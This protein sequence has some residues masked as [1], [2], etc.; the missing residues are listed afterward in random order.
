MKDSVAGLSSND[1]DLSVTP[2]VGR[3]D[4]ARQWHRRGGRVRQERFA[5]ACGRAAHARSVGAQLAA[6]SPTTT[7]EEDQMNNVQLIGRLTKDPEVITTPGEETLCSLRIAV[8]RMGRRGSTGY[9][10]V[11]VFGRSGAAAGRVLTEGWLVGVYGQL[12]FREWESDG[13]KRN[14]LSVT[15]NVEFLAAPRH[16]QDTDDAVDHALE[17]AA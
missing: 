1:A 4:S 5:L 10:D 17:Q 7:S 13:V 8:D 11:T 15:G 16:Q 14:A 3:F 2:E 6:F 12:R 9:V